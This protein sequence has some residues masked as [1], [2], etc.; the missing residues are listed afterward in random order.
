MGEISLTTR[1]QTTQDVTWDSTMLQGDVIKVALVEDNRL[2][3][4]ALTSLL[5]R[6]DCAPKF[7]PVEGSVYATLA[8]LKPSDSR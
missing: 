2:V 5:N 8:G 1:G 3:R 4:E 7:D 6:G